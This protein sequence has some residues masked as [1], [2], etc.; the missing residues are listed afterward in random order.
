MFPCHPA[1]LLLCQIALFAQSDCEED[2]QHSAGKAKR[3]QCDR[4]DFALNARYQD[5]AEYAGDHDDAD[6]AKHDDARAK[7]HHYS[8]SVALSLR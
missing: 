7:G 2:E 5:G 1:L 6:C 3:E 8:Y 4:E